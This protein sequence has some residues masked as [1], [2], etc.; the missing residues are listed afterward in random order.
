VIAIMAILA[1]AIAPALIRYINKSRR[2][3]DV[4]T[5][6]VINHAVEYAYAEAY[7]YEGKENN[8]QQDADHVGT[9]IIRGITGISGE[10]AYDLE[11]ISVA[12]DNETFQNDE[13]EMI[14]F[15]T[16]V[17]KTLGK[18]Q[19]SDKVFST[20]KYKKDSGNGLPEGFMIARKLDDNDE[21]VR[22]E[23][24][25]SKDGDEPAYRLYPDCCKEYK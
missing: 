9:N 23:V 18:E 5:A 25:I 16:L 11:I 21:P 1:A 10:D 12:K 15:M 24:W 20:P 13:D 22:F 19:N 6:S 2:A 3:S 4:E 14:H 8:V 17:R 7:S